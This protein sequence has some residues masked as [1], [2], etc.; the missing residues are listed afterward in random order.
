MNTCTSAPNSL[1]VSRGRCALAAL[2]TLTQLAL[3]PATGTAADDATRITEPRKDTRVE[4]PVVL[5]WKPAGQRMTI[6]FYQAGALLKKLKD[7]RSGEAYQIPPGM[8]EAKI[9]VEGESL[10][11]DSVWFTATEASR[12]QLIRPAK[13]A[14]LES[15]LR[16]EWRPKDQLMTVELY[17]DGRL[18]EKRANQ[19]SGCRI[20]VETPGRT[21]VKIWVEGE[22]KPRDSRWVTVE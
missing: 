6:E 3:W 5:E 20:P 8:T 16:I 11:T 17:Q 14:T 22:T 10:P 1:A 7:Q 18:I 19:K 21:E 2:L 12:G 9:W 13:N 15:P 4:S